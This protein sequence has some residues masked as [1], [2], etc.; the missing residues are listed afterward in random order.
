MKGRETSTP[1]YAKW[2]R[3]KLWRYIEAA[4]LGAGVEPPEGRFSLPG[5]ML[6][7]IV[8]RRRRTIAE[9]LYGHIKDAADLGRLGTVGSSR[10]GRIMDARI[11][12]DAFVVWLS[13]QS[14][15]VVPGELKEIGKFSAG[16]ENFSVKA[17]GNLLR[18]I[19]ALLEVI[20]GK[21]DVQKH[22]AFDSQTKLIEH[23]ACNYS[24][25]AG[26]SKR[27]LEKIFPE[28]KQSLS[29]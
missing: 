24:E 11:A 8:D 6:N 5:K 29:P 18:I 22:P 21:R 2:K 17:R 1:D 23:L 4:C 10:T 9:E 14:A 28:A 16:S 20:D 19:G 26:L 27:H 15:F 12:P 7:K 13:N 3:K 25:H